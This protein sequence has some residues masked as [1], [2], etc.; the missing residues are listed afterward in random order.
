LVFI[1]A[2]SF[3]EFFCL[4]ELTPAT[5]IAFVCISVPLNLVGVAIFIRMVWRQIRTKAM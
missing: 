4:W 3:V 1:L 2:G 5:F